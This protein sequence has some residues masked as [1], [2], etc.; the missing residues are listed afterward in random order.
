MYISCFKRVFDIILSLIA[1]IILSPLLLITAFLVYIKLGS[2]V[3]FRQVRPGKNGSLFI[4]YKF[5]SM[6]SALDDR[7]KLLPDDL[8]VNSF[9]KNLRNTSLD[10]LP[11][12]I[13][14]LKGDMSIVGP[15]P[16]LVRDMV[17]FTEEQMKRQSVYPGVTGLAQISGRNN[18]TWK[19]K[20][21]YDLEYIKNINF[22]EDIRIVYRTVFKVA[23]QV[24]INTEGMETA[25]DYGDY[26]L[27]IGEIS[28]ELYYEKNKVA[29]KM[30]ENIKLP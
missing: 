24:D 25:E 13:N 28:T 26:L 2:P 20:F 17:F 29:S 9:G 15:R 16:Q 3:L 14:V 19:E 23:M 27:R 7:G 11:E 22:F 30:L 4:M 8:R 18:V 6:T 10:E 5:R 12:L 21:R 1:L